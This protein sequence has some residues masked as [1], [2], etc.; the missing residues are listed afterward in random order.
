MLRLGRAPAVPARSI[1]NAVAAIAAS[2]CRTVVSAGRGPGRHRHVVEADHAQVG[3]GPQARA[4]PGPAARRRPGCR[5]RPR[6]RSAAAAASSRCPA[7]RRPPGTQKSSRRTSSGPAASPAACRAARY[8]SSRAR[9][10]HSRSGPPM[11]A[12]RRW[13]SSIRCRVAVRPPCQLVVP[14]DRMPGPGSSGRV[15]HHQRDPGRRQP[16]QLAAV[17]QVQHA[18]RAVGAPGG[19]PV[20]PPGELGRRVHRGDDHAGRRL[21]GG[22]HGAVQQF[23]GPRAVQA[24]DEQVHDAE[25]EPGGHLVAV[26]PQQRGDARPGPRGHVGPPVQ[27]LGHGGDGDA[28]LGRDAGQRGAPAV[29][30]HSS[31]HFSKPG[32][33]RLGPGWPAVTRAV[34][35][36]PALH[37]RR[38][39]PLDRGG[40]KSSLSSER[41]VFEN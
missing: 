3:R 12:I 37:G 9:L 41:I 34:P 22:L 16:L 30:C 21:V 7:W 40:G 24:G 15:D 14:T 4:R 20:Q 25:T 26:A 6:S 32:S 31:P 8:P 28:R 11:M 38:S 23:L 29:S 2:G 36:Q 5:S 33:A 17:R 10:D 39:R 19:G 18:Q 1:R 13:P 35:V 27:H